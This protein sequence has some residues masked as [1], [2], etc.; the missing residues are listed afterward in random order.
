MYMVTNSLVRQQMLTVKE[1]ASVQTKSIWLY[2]K[3]SGQKV[4][5]LYSCSYFFHIQICMNFP[6]T[7]LPAT[8]FNHTEGEERNPPADWCLLTCAVFPLWQPTPELKHYSEGTGTTLHPAVG[9]QP[10]LQTARVGSQSEGGRAEPG[11][12]LSLNHHKE[13]LWERWKV[14]ER[15]C[16]KQKDVMSRK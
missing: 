13:L 9:A 5:T 14:R 2:Y 16:Q 7:S 1:K 12:C 6:L 3:K 15:I 8:R 4:S 11:N 10:D